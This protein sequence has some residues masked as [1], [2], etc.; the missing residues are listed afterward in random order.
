MCI[1][2]GRTPGGRR[3]RR[4]KPIGANHRA[5]FLQM[6]I[7]SDRLRDIGDG[8]LQWCGSDGRLSTDDVRELSQ[9]IA[10]GVRAACSGARLSTHAVSSIPRLNMSS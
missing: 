5:Q 1:P 4:S 10:N 2:A 7:W 9:A 8:D 3:R 6:S